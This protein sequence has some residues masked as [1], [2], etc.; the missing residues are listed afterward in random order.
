MVEKV[1]DSL[2][3]IDES[4]KSKAKIHTHTPI[5]LKLTKNNHC[6]ILNTKQVQLTPSIT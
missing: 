2:D 4:S 3:L 1:Y 6:D 5:E